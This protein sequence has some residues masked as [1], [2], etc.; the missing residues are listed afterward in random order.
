MLVVW[1]MKCTCSQYSSSARSVEDALGADWRL[2]VIDQRRRQKKPGA[3]IFD[4]FLKMLLIYQNK[5]Y[6][7]GYSWWC[8]AKLIN[9]HG[10]NSPTMFVMNSRYNSCT[11]INWSL[12]FLARHT[13]TRLKW[14]NCC[15]WTQS[16]QQLYWYINRFCWIHYGEQVCTGWWILNDHDSKTWTSSC[17]SL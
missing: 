5:S 17:F 15:D 16:R 2:S 4:V 7:V 13:Q 10:E 14:E 9:F 6:F 1:L 11:E 8:E 3:V 12:W